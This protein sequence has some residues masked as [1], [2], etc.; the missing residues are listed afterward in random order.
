METWR[1]RATTIP[2]REGGEGEGVTI[3]HGVVD[4]EKAHTKTIEDGREEKG[5][6]S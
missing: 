2:G 6:F 3:S 1:R 4:T 5:R